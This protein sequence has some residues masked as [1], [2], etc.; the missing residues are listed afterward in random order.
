MTV[1]PN[2]FSISLTYTLA[3]LAEAEAVAVD[4]SGNAWVANY[5]TGAVVKLSPAGSSL[6]SFTGSISLP[7]AI[8]IDNSGNA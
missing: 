8:A 4:A 6:A 2:D 5:S 3:S 1:Q 7:T